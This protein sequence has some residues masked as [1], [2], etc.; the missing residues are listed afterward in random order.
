MKRLWILLAASAVIGCASGEQLGSR[1]DDMWLATKVR[2][3]LASGSLSSF[4]TIDVSAQNGV[5]ILDGYVATAEEKAKV[6]ELVRPPRGVG[7]TRTNP[8]VG[9]PP[10]A[11]AS[12]HASEPAPPPGGARTG[13]T[14]GGRR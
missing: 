7:E 11:P 3:R 6:E 5:I 14:F 10:P 8:A 4:R 2:S 1:V 12:S 9:V 13:T